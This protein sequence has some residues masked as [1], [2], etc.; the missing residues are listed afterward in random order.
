LEKL[1][2]YKYFV[3]Y[4]NK[5]MPF[6]NDEDNFRMMEV[7]LK[8]IRE[9]IKGDDVSWMGFFKEKADKNDLES[10]GILFD[11]T[12]PKK[13]NEKKKKSFTMQLRSGKKL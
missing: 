4:K 3:F 11:D 6:Q 9:N 1:K 13:E 8:I 2:R 10:I 12:N 7:L 5:K